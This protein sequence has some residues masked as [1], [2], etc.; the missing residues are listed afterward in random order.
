MNRLYICDNLLNNILSKDKACF[1]RF[2][3]SGLKRMS[4]SLIKMEIQSSKIID[5][6]QFDPLNDDDSLKIANDRRELDIHSN[7]KVQIIDTGVYEK[8]KIVP[9]IKNSPIDAS[10]L[11][12]KQSFSKAFSKP[13][14]IKRPSMQ[15]KSNSNNSEEVMPIMPSQVTLK[16][17]PT[18]DFSLPEIPEAPI[19]F[20]KSK[21]N[22]KEYPLTSNHMYLFSDRQPKTNN[23]LRQIHIDNVGFNDAPLSFWTQNADRLTTE[24]GRVAIDFDQLEN[25]FIHIQSNPKLV[26][27]NVALTANYVI[28]SQRISNISIIL[29]K[30]HKTAADVHEAALSGD[31][32]FLNEDTIAILTRAFPTPEEEILLQNSPVDV[33]SQAL[34]NPENFLR[35][36]IKFKN[37]RVI[38]KIC[39]IFYKIL[40]ASSILLESLTNIAEPTILSISCLNLQIYIALCVKIVNFLNSQQSKAGAQL[41]SFSSIARIAKTTTHKTGRSIS[42]FACKFLLETNKSF[43]SFT[44]SFTEYKRT[45]KID[46][47]KLV[48]DVEELKRQINEFESNIILIESNEMDYKCNNFVSLMR[49]KLTTYNERYREACRQLKKNQDLFMQ[50]KNVFVLKNYETETDFFSDLSQILA[51]IEESICQ[52][53]TEESQGKSSGFRKVKGSQE[54]DKELNLQI[55]SFKKVDLKSK[56]SIEKISKYKKETIRKSSLISASKDCKIEG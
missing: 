8:E 39:S 23:S 4:K 35:E 36:L 45:F 31:M 9:Q 38:L 7:L 51:T 50:A 10:K 29:S 28:D 15:N 53:S 2:L 46:F 13:P 41:T 27:N 34:R 11:D 42:Y 47:S 5:K 25:E 1:S 40:S 56:T 16:T 48:T 17:S 3:L 14:T 30:F 19:I 26:K 6:D 44:K 24:L 43:F 52:I 18:E 21:K 22:T 20:M 54:Q 49:E 32:N 37:L 33:S 12:K 55:S